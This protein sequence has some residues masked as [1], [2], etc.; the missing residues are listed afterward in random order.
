MNMYFTMHVFPIN[1]HSVWCE[2]SGFHSASQV[3]LTVL[4]RILL[5]YVRTHTFIYYNRC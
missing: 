1:D 3:I 4:D 5:A 2:W